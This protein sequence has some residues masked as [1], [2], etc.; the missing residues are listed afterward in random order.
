MC[1]DHPAAWLVVW[2]VVL[3]SLGERSVGHWVPPSAFSW[4]A[5]AEQFFP[6]LAFPWA[7]QEAW[8]AVGGLS[9]YSLLNSWLGAGDTP[10]ARGGEGCLH[11]RAAS[12]VI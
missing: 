12:V 8:Q 1:P 3:D 5:H 7:A 6:V 9:L 2:G 10:Q 11:R 4:P